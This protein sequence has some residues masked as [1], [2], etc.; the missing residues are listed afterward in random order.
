M[1]R[2]DGASSATAY[3]EGGIQALQTFR[4][5]GSTSD[6]DTH[7]ASLH[8]EFEQRPPR[9]GRE[10]GQRIQALAGLQKS[11]SPVRAYLHRAGLQYRKVAPIPSKANPEVQETFLTEPREPIL[12]EAQAGLRH[13]FFVGALLAICG[14]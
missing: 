9:S 10:A 11:P 12:A 6:R 5:G 14:V 4:V 1:H 2:N 8:E 13:V 7:T 3:Q